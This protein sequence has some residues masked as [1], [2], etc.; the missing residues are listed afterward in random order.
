MPDW[1]G[2]WGRPAATRLSQVRTAERRRG[3]VPPCLR[4]SCMREWCLDS[5]PHFHG[6][7]PCVAFKR[8]LPL[9]VRVSP[10]RVAWH[11]GPKLASCPSEVRERPG[12]RSSPPLHASTAM[13]KFNIALGTC[14]SGHSASSCGQT[15]LLGCYLFPWLAWCLLCRLLHARPCTLVG[16]LGNKPP[17]R[18]FPLVPAALPGAGIVWVPQTVQM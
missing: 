1:S 14:R 15:P 8:C 3:S 13:L 2:T 9:V 10:S 5:M 11:T 17:S 18:F 6:H 4:Q 12:R 7:L 16:C